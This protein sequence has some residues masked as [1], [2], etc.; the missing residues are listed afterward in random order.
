MTLGR[1]PLRFFALVVMPLPESITPDNRGVVAP[2]LTNIGETEQT[3]N[4]LEPPVQI[5]QLW[6]SSTF[7]LGCTPCQRGGRNLMLSQSSWDH[8]F[9]EPL[10]RSN[11]D[12]F[13][14]AAQHVHSRKVGGIK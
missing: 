7:E 9:H 5:Q 2:V 13:V 11:I 3:E 8:Q 1:C 6:N 10:P 14:P 12:E 4:E